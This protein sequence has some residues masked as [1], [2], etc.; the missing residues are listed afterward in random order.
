[1]GLP[2]EQ[3]AAV[4]R[5]EGQET[6]APVKTVPVPQEPGPG[7]IL[8]KI[9]WTGLCASDK[10]LLHDEWQVFGVKMMEQS[11][12]IAGHEGAGEVVAVHP[13]VSELW[14][15]GDRAGVKWVAS[16]CRHCE[17]CTNGTDELHCP[18]QL[19]S[20]LSVPGTFQEY[21]LTDGRYATR[22]P[23]GV[24]DE[25]AGPIMCGGVTAYT[26]CKRS[27]VK[28]G[29]W[30]VVIGAGGGLGH[31]G[32]QYAKAMGMRVIAID[33]GDEKDRLCKDLGAEAYIDY[34]KVQDLPA[35]VLRLTTY[36]A[37]GI[38]V[39]AASRQGYQ[40][41]PALARPGGTIVAVG[42]PAQADII[43]GAP[44][45]ALAMKRLNIVGSV[46][47]TLKDVEEALDF[48][49]RDLVHPILTKGTLD[50]VDKFCKLLSEGKLPG[51]AVLKV[52]A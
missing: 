45:V 18:K 44:P 19:N 8:V 38:I 52:A 7:Q 3:R 37:H 51:R 5:G 20:G 35:E 40:V 15:V 11:S 30:L 33:G 23:A 39:F 26:A 13:D 2:T 42:L 41:A 9:N 17:F 21:C 31:F 22:I 49:A 24:S 36:G 4:R 28:P 12:G 6:T 16:V 1:M 43:A 10:S 27:A 14:K 48:C 34:T 25:E 46:T 47:G 32:V 50:D 29:Q